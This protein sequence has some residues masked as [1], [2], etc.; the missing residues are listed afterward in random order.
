MKKKLLTRLI[1]IIL[2]GL[3][4][5]LGWLKGTHNHEQ[6]RIVVSQTEEAEH[7]HEPAP[8]EDKV[9]YTCGMHPWI[10]VDEPGICPICQMDLTPLKKTVA[11]GTKAGGERTIKY[12]VSPMDPT[13]IRDEPGKSPM[14]M[15]LVPVYEDEVVTGSLISIDPVT[16]QNMGIRTA[17]VEP[18]NLTR[19]IRTSGLIDY[20]EPRQYAVN[21]KID[22]WIEK[23]YINETGIAVK[24]GQPLL[25]IYSPELVA[26]QDEFLLALKNYQQLKDSPYEE[27]AS[28]AKRLLEASKNKLKLWDIS[29]KQLKRLQSSGQV[30]RTLTLYAPYGGIVTSKQATE[31]SFIKSGSQLFNIADL[32]KIWVFADI[33]ESELPL[34]HEGQKAEIILPFVGDKRIN[35]TVSTIYPYVDPRTRT[36]KARIDL[37][38][39]NFELRPDMYV[40]VRLHSEPLTA[41][42][43]V[44]A[45]AVIN[46]GEK[47]TVFVRTM[48]GRFEPRLVKT[49]LLSDDGYLQIIQGVTAKDVVVTSAQFLLD[50]ES[51]LQEAIQKMLEP[52][53]AP[54]PA[55]EAAETEQ[56]E[57]LF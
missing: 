57:D 53:T 24:K 32:S 18:R 34:V 5:S 38:N 49:G 35:G 31:G 2:I 33:Y 22:G 15:D 1:V 56:L 20:E 41:A 29:A 45:E 46:S 37:D 25:E 4:F 27:I 47:Q 9:Q 19:L 14:G 54:V 12:W 3:A 23:L 7:S 26:A 51:Q 13:F 6:E 48:D 52:Q 39:S 36:V 40:N 55:P 21:T 11:G 16:Q 28:G 50:S 44:P 42:L 10:I 17:Q 43:S 30:R 8:G